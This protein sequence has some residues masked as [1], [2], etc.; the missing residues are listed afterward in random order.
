MNKEAIG[1]Y[2]GLELEEMKSDFLTSFNYKVNSCRN[3]LLLVLIERKIKD[4]YLPYYTCEVIKNTLFGQGIN[5]H[6][7]FLDEN[8]EI[9]DHQIP[10]KDI[11]LL[12]TN[13]FGIKDQYIK[14]LKDQYT[15]LIIDNAQALY[16]EFEGIDC[17]YSP[18]KFVGVPD[19][20]FIKTDLKINISSFENDVSYDRFSHLL[21]RVELSP[22]AG[23]SDFRE[24]D[25]K[26]ENL[27]IRKISL[28]TSR[29]LSHIDY[30]NIKRIRNS[31]FDFLH[32]KLSNI[33]RLKIG[34]RV[35]SCPMVYPLY[36]ENAQ[37]IRQYL[38]ENRIFVANYWNSV[39]ENVPA[40][41]HEHRFVHHIL[42]LPIDQ[43]Y[44]RVHMQKIIQ[45]IYDNRA[46]S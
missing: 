6:F 23:Y 45:L 17:V 32:T 13:Y 31:N 37:E 27:P 14:G 44:T 7:Y 2:F 30:K 26:I 42:A 36:L 35:N 43:R 18:R 15:Y 12:Y 21:K 24:N 4:L 29:T 41:S 34:F 5:L 20:G 8:L 38:I 16:S 39:L 1:G 19:G 10:S 22:E 33:N 25:A 46:I 28:L 9:D 40:D 3:A 11:A